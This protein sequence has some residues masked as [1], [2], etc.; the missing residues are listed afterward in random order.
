V[1]AGLLARI[2]LGP[3]RFTRAV[4]IIHRR[5]RTLS[6]AAQEFVRVLLPSAH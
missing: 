2:D 6:A 5:G 4:G 3:G 1:K